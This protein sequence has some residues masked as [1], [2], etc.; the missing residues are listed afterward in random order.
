MWVKVFGL[1]GRTKWHRTA[2]YDVGYLFLSDYQ[3][4]KL[5]EG[6]DGKEVYQVQ[7]MIPFIAIVSDAPK[8]LLC[9]IEFEIWRKA[10][11]EEVENIHSILEQH[12]IIINDKGNFCFRDYDKICFHVGDRKMSYDEFVNDFEL[13]RGCVFHEVFDNEFSYCGSEPFRGDNKAYADTAIRI[14]KKQGYLWFH[15]SMGFRLDD[16]F[17]IH[18]AYGKDERYSEVS[19]S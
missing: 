4:E 2:K 19:N 13:P 9:Q 10:T 11:K 8:K 14:A 15:W 7:S 16:S 17:A 12:N 1:R 3:I 6:A 18:V 5:K